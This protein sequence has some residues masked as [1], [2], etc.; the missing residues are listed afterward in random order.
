MELSFANRTIRTSCEDEDDAKARYGLAMAKVLQSRLADI[1]A[2][3][4]IDEILVGQPEQI[5]NTLNIKIDLC[6]GYR[7]IC[8]ANHVHN[9]QDSNGKIDWKKVRRLKIIQIEKI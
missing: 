4:C 2:A 3:Y 9:P 6:D 5:P 8:C 1:D 7:L